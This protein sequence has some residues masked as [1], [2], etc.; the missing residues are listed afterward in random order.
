[1]AEE[2]TETPSVTVNESLH[3][4]VEITPALI[5]NALKCI[6]TASTRGA[7]QG[8]E[9]SSV[10]SVRDGLYNLVADVVKE[11]EKASKKED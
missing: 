9:L 2:V 7:F 5:I 4:P 11:L 10:G 8:G 1:M 6:D 3:T